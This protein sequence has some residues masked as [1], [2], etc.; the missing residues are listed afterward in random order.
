MKAW[1]DQDAKAKFNEFLDVCLTEGAQMVT[2]HG[3]EEWRRLQELRVQASKNYYACTEEFVAV[4][5]YH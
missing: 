4:S 1:P 3:V 5:R 2:G